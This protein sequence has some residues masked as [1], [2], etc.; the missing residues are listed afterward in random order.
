[1]HDLVRV[2]VHQ[3]AHVA[4]RLQ[5][6]GDRAELARGHGRERR[7]LAVGGE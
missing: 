7:E 3:H 1:V 5:V 4:Q 6:I 2:G